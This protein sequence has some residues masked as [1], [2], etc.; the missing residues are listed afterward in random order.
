MQ[1]MDRLSRA[2]EASVRE[3]L[4]ASAEQVARVAAQGADRGPLLALDM[5][6][7]VSP[8]FSFAFKLDLITVF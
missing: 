6:E 7:D 8:N 3:G 5:D 2:V 4:G 1:F